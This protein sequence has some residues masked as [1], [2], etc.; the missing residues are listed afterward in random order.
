MANA[1]IATNYPI[2]IGQREK[3]AE[4]TLLRKHMPELDVFHSMSFEAWQ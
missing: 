4:V 2:E 1:A 3:S